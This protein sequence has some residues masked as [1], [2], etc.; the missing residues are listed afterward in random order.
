MCDYRY[1]VRVL[2]AI[3]EDYGSVYEDGLSFKDGD[4]ITDPSV[5]AEYLCDFEQALSSLGRKWEGLTSLEFKCYYKYS[6]YQRVIISDILGIL[7]EELEKYIKEAESLKRYAYHLM[8]QY[9]NG[10][11]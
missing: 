7:P 5:L 1:S 11:K 2:K 3:A 6:I 9:L 8:K 4:R 10:E